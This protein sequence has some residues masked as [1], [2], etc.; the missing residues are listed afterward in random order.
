[1]LGSPIL[2]VAIGMAFIYLLLSLI[3]SALQE[4]L[5][6]FLQARAANLQRGLR[7][8]FSNDKFN[9]DST[10]L[11][12]I[13]DH[14][15]VRGLYQDPDKDYFSNGKAT[16]V[17]RGIWS[18]FTWIKA[19]LRFALG[20]APP[21]IPFK[22]KDILLPAYIP[23]RTFALALI[24]V[25]NNPKPNGWDS[26]K[27]IEEN[28]SQVRGQFAGN[29]AVEALLALVKDAAGKPDKLQSNLENWYNDSMDR[30]SG[31]YKRYVQKILIMIGLALAVVFNVDSVQV[32]KVLWM[33][34]DARDA[35]VAAAGDYMKTHPD[36]AKNASTGPIQETN[37]K[38]SSSLDKP[39]VPEDLN[40][41]LK[42]TVD[43]FNKINND[44]MLPIGW[45]TSPLAS[46]TSF[47]ERKDKDYLKLM[48]LLAG[49]LIT[50]VALSLGAPFWFDTLNKFM[51]V[52]GTVKPQE[53]S[54]AEKSKDA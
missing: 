24:V 15:L 54:Q 23:S 43:A 7:S 5:A 21:G 16:K 33:D 36:K 37:S 27:N 8:L 39:L 20:V 13:Y 35:A 10:L 48:R 4:I 41:R 52:R 28:L 22:P 53:K 14:G 9:S 51:V 45:R 49:W 6:S 38:T 47:W 17:L 26:L 44:S 2:D 46:F 25:L 11:E 29:K 18:G 12:L 40:L 50:A 42:T 1:M 30:V 3:A 34:K 19:L 32:A 31:W